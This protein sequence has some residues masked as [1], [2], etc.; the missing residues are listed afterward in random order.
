V[1]QRLQSQITPRDSKA[2][3]EAYKL[4]QRTSLFGVVVNALLVAVKLISGILGNSYAL[5]ADATE[6][7]L[8]IVGSLIVWSG[9]RVGARPADHDHPYGHGKAEPLAAMFISMSLMGAAVALAIQSVREILTPHHAPAPFTLIVIV[10]VVIVKEM[11]YRFVINVGEIIDSTAVRA[12]AWH[13]RSD[14]ITSLAAFVGIA[15]AVV[16]G[17][18]Y[19]SADDWAALLACGIIAF[20]GWRMLR[21]ALAEV[22]DAAPGAELESKVRQVAAAVPGVAGLHRCRV[23]KYGV[24]YIVDLQVIVDGDLPVRRG[25]EIAHQVKDALKASALNIEDVVVHIEPTRVADEH[26]SN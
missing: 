20:N 9:L 11:L 5:I 14:A 3:V 4:G 16:A 23:R 18:G 2:I 26:T 21:P 12:D 6:S 13:H 8:D 17:E 25:H 22:M 15:I 24:R 1:P 10:A 7:T 19:E